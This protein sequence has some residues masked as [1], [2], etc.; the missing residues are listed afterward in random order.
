MTEIATAIASP[1]I[2]STLCLQS[3]VEPLPA[4]TVSLEKRLGRDAK[5]SSSEGTPKA[6]SELSAR[7]GTP[8]ARRP[9]VLLWNQVDALSYKFNGVR[10]EYNYTKIM[11][12]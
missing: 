5:G 2:Q 12:I 3:T 6:S 7:C 8:G 1:R 4:S 9:V 10:P 11:S